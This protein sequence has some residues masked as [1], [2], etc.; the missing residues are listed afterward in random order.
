M[1]TPRTTTRPARL[2]RT[3]ALLAAALALPLALSSCTTGAAASGDPTPG[4]PATAGATTDAVTADTVLSSHGIT[5][6][7]VVEVIDT[8]DSQPLD[9][10]PEGLTASVRPRE[11]LVSDDQGRQAS[12]PLPED[13]F[14]LSVAPWVTGTHDCF[15]HSLTTCT[16]ELRDTA[17]HMRVTDGATGEVLVDADLRT[18]DNGFV[19]LWL[20]RGIQDATLSVEAGGRSAT[21]QFSTGGDEDATCLTTLQLG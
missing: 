4:T 17:V 14:Y 9:E 3:G 15:F 1:D 21:T 18:H 12:L 16:G 20:P 8:L 7:D 6:T 11:L 5:T 13:S 10:R 2:R 19:G